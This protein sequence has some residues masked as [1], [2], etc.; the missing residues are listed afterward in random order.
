MVEHLKD[1]LNYYRS[2]AKPVW[3]PAIDRTSNPKQ[4]G[5][6]WSP[7]ITLQD[8]SSVLASWAAVQTLFAGQN[9]LD[10]LQ[11]LTQGHLSTH[12]GSDFQQDFRSQEAA[13]LSKEVGGSNV[14]PTPPSPAPLCVPPVTI[15]D[16]D[17][18]F[19]F[20]SDSDSDLA[21]TFTYRSSLF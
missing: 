10:N 13:S 1:R 19:Y 9:Q 16:G 12:A 20:D 17:F 8:N 5:G 21:L 2:T 11:N 15:K 3:Y 18:Y 14:C 6:F 7:W 4:F